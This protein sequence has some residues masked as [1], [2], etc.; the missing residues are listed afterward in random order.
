MSYTASPWKHS[1][2]LDI[3]R[4]PQMYPASNPFKTGRRF[5]LAVPLSV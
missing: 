3:R 1:L 5:A 4:I 2:N